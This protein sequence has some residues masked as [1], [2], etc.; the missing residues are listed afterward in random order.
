[1]RRITG[2]IVADGSL[3]DDHQGTPA[4]GYK[5]SVFVEGALGGLTFNRDW[6]D[7]DGESYYPDPSL[8]AGE[9]LALA[10]RAAGIRGPRKIVIR[11]GTTPSSAQPVAAVASPPMS[12]LVAL[13]NTPSDDFFAEML[14]KDLGAQFGTG[15]TT[16][17]GAAVV[18]AQIAQSFGLHPRLNDGSGLSRYDRTTP[19]QVIS[20]LTQQHSNSVFT[21]SLAIAGE[22]GTLV[23]EMNHTVAQGRCEGKTGTL[24]DVSN[25]V[26]YCTAADGHTLTFAILMNGVDP[27]AAHPIQDDMVEAIARSRG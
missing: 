11:D 16:A 27:Y 21:G 5:P 25:L 13:T 6:S 17:A 24:H 20:L 8:E 26:G 19:A 10:L 2:P 4:T 7:S 22:T 1:M 23:D 18:R 14:L 3:F 9:Q 12:Q 15:G